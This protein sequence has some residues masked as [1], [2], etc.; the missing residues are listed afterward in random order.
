MSNIE[1]INM[2]T[3]ELIQ[4]SLEIFKEKG[5]K[6]ECFKRLKSL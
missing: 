3:D 1:I 6:K 4:D 2:F 5:D